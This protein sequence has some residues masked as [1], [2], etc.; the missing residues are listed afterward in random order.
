MAWTVYLARCADGSLYTGIARDAAQRIAAHNT[1]R[2]AAYTR[3]R[4]PV[5]LVHTESA[6]DRS[7]A[8]R[9]EWAIKQLS[10]REKESLIMS[11]R[12][13]RNDQQGRFP[14]F[15]PAALRFLAQ[16]KRH[17]TKPWFEANRAR[18]EL[19]V[20]EPLRL[21]V[22]EVDVRL[23]RLAPEMVG[24]PKRSMFRIHR[25]VRF[26]RDKSPYKTH[27]ACW[28][29]HRDAG[30]GV[31]QD[32]SGGAGFY[33][34]LEPGQCLIG[35]GIWMPPR[36]A[37]SRIRDALVEDQAGFEAIV[38]DRGFRRRYGSLDDEA[39]LTRPPRGFTE[40]HPAARWLRY[41]CFTAG[42]LL[43]ERA[44]TSPRLVERLAEDYERLA[45]LVRWLNRSLGFRAIDRRL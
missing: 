35:A 2:G 20:R 31:G 42:R 45:P 28:F 38:E 37:L 21:L 18:Y 39:M 11:R 23:A 4:R 7:A 44:V 22:E 8:L 43:T 30:R 34:H 3:S 16:L 1:G 24:D 9:R 5:A 29:Y 15:R 27:A 25:D 32:A 40:G 19:E 6:L 13:M 36:P 41:Q 10:R 14:G 26:S 12:R 17:N 33:F